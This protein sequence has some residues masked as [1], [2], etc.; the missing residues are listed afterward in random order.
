MSVYDPPVGFHFSVTF[1][2]PAASARDVRFRDVSGLSMELEEMS[3][4][5]GGENRFSH[6]LPVR[7]RYPDLSLKRGLLLDT[8]LKDWIRDA[9]QN[10][11][12]SP[13][14]VWIKLLGPDHEPLQTYTVTGAW[15]K[16]WSVSDFSAENSAIVV[17]S[18]DLAYRYFRVD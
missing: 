5:E 3:Y 15:P 11:V 18:L 8:G 17:E 10:L 7:A 1:D 6:R 4:A 16:K 14:T 13:V 2:L 12:V 9:V